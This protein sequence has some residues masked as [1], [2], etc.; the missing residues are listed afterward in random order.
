M[1]KTTSF[2]D[3]AQA[4][5]MMTAKTGVGVLAAEALVNV[6]NNKKDGGTRMKPVIAHGIATLAGIAALAYTADNAPSFADV[7]N[8]FAAGSFAN[9]VKM[10]LPED[11]RKMLRL[12]GLAAT[13]NAPATEAATADYWTEMY[14]RH[15]GMSGADHQQDTDDAGTEMANL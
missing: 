15:A 2:F 13:D 11:N 1:A 6:V 7:A 9:T 12:N 10:A 5:A 4:A 8:G 3:N 14:N